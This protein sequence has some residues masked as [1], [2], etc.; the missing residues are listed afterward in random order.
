M[1]KL[2]LVP[3][4]DYQTD[5][6]T[7]EVDPGASAEQIKQAYRDQTKVWH[8]DR[9]ANDVRLQKKAEEKI[10]E[11]TLA[12]RRLSG[13]SAYEQQVPRPAIP[14]QPSDW[15]VAALALGRAIRNTGVLI[16]KPVGLLI[17]T[18]INVCSGV[19]EWCCHERK[20]ITIAMSAFVVGFAFGVWLLPRDSET[21]VKIT[22]LFQKTIEKNGSAP[23]TVAQASA[24]VATPIQTTSIPVSSPGPAPSVPSWPA[25]AKLHLNIDGGSMNFPPSEENAAIP[26]PISDQQITAVSSPPYVVVLETDWLQNLG[27]SN[28]RDSPATRNYMPVSFIPS[29][30][31]FYLAAPPRD[32]EQRQSTIKE[33]SVDSPSD[34]IRMEPQRVSARHE[35]DETDTVRKRDGRPAGETSRIDTS[36]DDTSASRPAVT[37]ETKSAE[38]KKPTGEVSVKALQTRRIQT[39]TVIAG[40]TAKAVAIYAPRPDYPEEARSR[41]IGGSGVCVVSIDPYSGHVTSASMAQSTGSLLLDKSVVRTLRSWKFKPGTMSHVSIPVQFSSDEENR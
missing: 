36:Q 40:S 31:S 1:E 15:G 2:R 34:Q 23:A 22:S 11:I 27:R 12:Y 30:I 33:A 13:V 7:L 8:P 6:R 32:S 5:C 17:G 29:E 16:L 28:Y 21:W 38:R 20:S 26:S 14:E 25:E 41:R 24:P 3:L 18:A 37:L 35:P 39:G 10:K 19:F 9:F 4:S